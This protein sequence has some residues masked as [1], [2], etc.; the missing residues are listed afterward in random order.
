MSVFEGT[1][2]S[3]PRGERLVL[4]NLRFCL[5]R[6]EV[7]VLRGA[8]G[9]GKSTLLRVMAGLV[10]PRS[11]TIMWQGRGVHA[12]AD[13]HR[14]RLR[15]LGH[16]DGLKAA[17][18]ARENLEFAASL[19]EPAG[20]DKAASLNMSGQGVVEGALARW[21]LARIAGTPA[22]WLSAG[23]RRRTA[24]ARLSLAPRALWLLD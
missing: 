16:T 24:L 23:Q 2:L 4:A 7:L 21:G 3:V 20:L 8:N 12:D 10:R 19:D 6:G 1:D 17:L 14:A 11:G 22:R 9:A 18:T 5:A 15:Y 13:A